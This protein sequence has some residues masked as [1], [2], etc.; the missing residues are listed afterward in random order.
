MKGRNREFA[1]SESGNHHESDAHGFP[2]RMEFMQSSSECASSLHVKSSKDFKPRAQKM[3]STRTKHKLH[4]ISLESR[5]KIR[6]AM[7]REWIKKRC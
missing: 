1:S 2:C 4:A 6:K 3:K 5:C 7:G